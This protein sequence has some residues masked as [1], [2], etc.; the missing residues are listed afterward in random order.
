MY[1]DYLDYIWYWIIR[2]KLD[3]RNEECGWLLEVIILII[4]L[5]EKKKRFIMVVRWVSIIKIEYFYR[6]LF[7]VVRNNK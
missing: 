4:R 6:V 1:D 2:V 5:F 3:I 7:R